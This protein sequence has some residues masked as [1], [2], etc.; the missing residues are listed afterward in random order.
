MSSSKFTWDFTEISN[1][2]K[3]IKRLKKNSNN[4]NE[5]LD[6][7]LDNYRILLNSSNLDKLYDDNKDSLEDLIHYYTIY[8]KDLDKPISESILSFIKKNGYKTLCE[9]D[10]NFNLNSIEINDDELEDQAYDLFGHLD[11]KY[12]KYLGNIIRNRLIHIDKIPKDETNNYG[13]TYLDYINFLG[14]ALINNESTINLLSTFN[15]EITHIL[16]IMINPGLTL[17]EGIIF[18]EARAL[19]IDILTLYRIYQSNNNNSLDAFKEI[20]NII[21][22]YKRSI[23]DLEIINHLSYIDNLSEKNVVS[24]LKRNYGISVYNKKEVIENICFDSIDNISYLYSLLLAFHMLDNY[25][26]DEEKGIYLFNKSMETDVTNNIKYLT[27]LEFNPND[28]DYIN[29]LHKKYNN[30]FN[31]SRVRK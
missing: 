27:T 25:I 22:D 10:Y 17:E 28:S 12:Q 6:N 1:R 30:K 14:Y 26:K 15:H 16:E 11:K 29:D 8:M 23:S 13:K 19:F 4:T 5:Y 7:T 24:S 2:Y 31:A 3:E 21:N 9:K 18:G 20:I